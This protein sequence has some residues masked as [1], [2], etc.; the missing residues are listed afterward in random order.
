MTTI[1]TDSP[2]TEAE[3]LTL[4]LFAGAVIP[5]NAEYDVPG[6]D[7]P[8]IVADILATAWRYDEAVAAGA[9]VPGHGGNGQ[10]R[11]AVRRP[12]GRGPD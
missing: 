9:K 6:A 8:D 3:L 7:D 1:A 4:T 11:G 2:F 10:I 12:V 5:A